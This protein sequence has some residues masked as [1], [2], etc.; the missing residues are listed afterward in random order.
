MAHLGVIPGAVTP[1]ALVN[2]RERLV[3]P[4]IDEG[5]LAHELVNVHPLR[6]DRTTTM[7]TRDLM[8]FVAALGYEA[9]VMG[10]PG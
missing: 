6:N 8:R 2:D 1:L 7:R 9:R 5:L 3:Q 4:V 10:L